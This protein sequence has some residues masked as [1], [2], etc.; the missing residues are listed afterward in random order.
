MTQTLPDHRQSLADAQD[1]V[2]RLLAAVRPDQ[3][4]QPTPCTDFTVIELVAHLYKVAGRVRVLGLGGDPMTEDFTVAELPD[5]VLAGLRERVRTAQL[6][7][8]DDTSLGRTVRVPW[9]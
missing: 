8:T 4:H 2:V 9:G 7:W 6:A 3:L 5:D 1:W